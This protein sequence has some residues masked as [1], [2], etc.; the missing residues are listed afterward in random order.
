MTFPS[1]LGNPLIGMLPNRA[2][3]STFKNRTGNSPIP[4]N[5]GPTLIKFKDILLTWREHEVLPDDSAGLPARLGGRVLDL[6]DGHTHRRAPVG[7]L[8]KK[9]NKDCFYV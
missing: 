8:L 9:K 3:S 2:E 4:I 7:L 5:K 1:C 6:P